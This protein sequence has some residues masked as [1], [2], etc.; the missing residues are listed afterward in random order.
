MTST[1]MPFRGGDFEEVASAGAMLRRFFDGGGPSL[2]SE[3]DD[4]SSG[5]GLVALGIFYN[6]GRKKEATLNMTPSDAAE[7]H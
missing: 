1:L 2:S 4:V 5:G 6:E 3:K 7:C